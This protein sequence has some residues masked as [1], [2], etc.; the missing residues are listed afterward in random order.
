MPGEERLARLLGPA[1]HRRAAA[2][3]PPSRRTAIAP[4]SCTA[5]AAGSPR[6]SPCGR[7]PPPRSHSSSDGARAGPG[8]A[9]VPDPDKEAWARCALANI[10][11]PRR[12]RGRPGRRGVRRARGRGPRALRRRT[13]DLRRRRRRAPREHR[14]RGGVA[15][16]G[17][18]AA[19]R[20][21]SCP[22][23]AVWEPAHDDSDAA[24]FALLYAVGGE[25]RYV[26][27]E[28]V[29][30]APVRFD[31]GTWT[32]AG[33]LQP[34]RARSPA[35]PSPAALVHR[36]PAGPR[37]D[38]PGAAVRAHLRRRD[39]RRAALGRPRARARRRAGRHGVRR[40]R[41]G[42]QLRT[43]GSGRAGR[44]PGGGHDHRGRARR[45][46]ARAS[47]AAGSW[48]AAASRRRG[49]GSRSS[50]TAT[51]RRRTVTR[52]AVT[53]ADGTFSLRA[54]RS[55]RPPASG[56]SPRRSARR[57]GRSASCPAC[58]SGCASAPA[59]PSPSRAGS[60]PP[61][62]AACCCCGAAPS[63]PPRPAARRGGRFTLRLRAPRAGRYQ[64][65]F[66]PSGERAERS[67]S[68]TGVIR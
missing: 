30:G 66:I 40:R 53:Q 39:G 54:A 59:A 47:A 33:G 27:G 62:P 31:H 49:P 38:R 58:G 50:S 24:G 5:P 46:A 36:P 1:P 19:C 29:R 64:V 12:R 22:R 56:P 11:H 43:G 3:R 41:R 63:I 32:A 9:P 28:A 8:C 23:V 6:R 57:R 15:L 4:S 16:R 60:G 42:R 21:S 65:V 13:A 14:R 34:A 18:R 55:A 51:A 35:S 20:R 45:P 25:T 37:R 2:R 7:L 44:P 68:N 26:R 17:G 10:H 52:R 48:S 67:T 61:C